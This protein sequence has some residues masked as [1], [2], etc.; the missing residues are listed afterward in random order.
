MREVLGSPYLPHHL[1]YLDILFQAKLKS[2]DRFGK[3]ILWKARVTAAQDRRQ[4]EQAAELG[5]SGMSGKSVKTGSVPSKSISVSNEAALLSI[6]EILL[7][8]KYPSSLISVAE[9]RQTIKNRSALLL[10]Q[11]WHFRK[12]RFTRYTPNIERVLRSRSLENSFL[13]ILNSCKRT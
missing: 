13:E 1:R 12:T 5:G 11:T 2:K 7:R 9:W 6:E 10:I 4:V 8:P 3:Y